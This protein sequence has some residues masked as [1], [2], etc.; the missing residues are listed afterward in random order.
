MAKKHSLPRKD[1][2]YREAIAYVHHVGFDFHSKNVHTALFDFLDPSLEAGDLV[3]ELG[4]G[5]GLLAG[6]ILEYGYSYIGI[7]LSKE[8]LAIARRLNPKATFVRTS[9]YQYKLP[10]SGAVIA[11]GEIFNYCFDRTVT[12][13]RLKKIFKAIYSSLKPGG[14]F[15]FDCAG[16]G[17]GNFEENRQRNFSG[18]DWALMLTTSEDKN[19][20]MLTRAME[21]FVKRGA[22]YQRDKETHQLR[23]FSRTNIKELLREAGFLVKIKSGIGTDDF[24][25]G[26][27][28]VVASKPKKRR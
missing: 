8:M 11:F 25:Q 3:V 7:D 17:R 10:N 28:A 20:Q 26:L 4:C 13:A 23:L 9:V 22:N 14:S 15:I 18:D 24:P 16:P 12:L 1:N 19:K 2:G 5:T 6:P 27:F 21:S